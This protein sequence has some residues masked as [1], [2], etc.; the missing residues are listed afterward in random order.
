MWMDLALCIGADIKG[1]YTEQTVIS[2]LGNQAE[3]PLRCF[4]N[5]MNLNSSGKHVLEKIAVEILPVFL[6]H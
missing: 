6:T 5:I 2:K 3:K 1:L 4:S